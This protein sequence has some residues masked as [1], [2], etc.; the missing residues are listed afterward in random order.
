MKLLIFY[1]QLSKTSGKPVILS[2]ISDYSNAYVPVSQL[3]D[4]S[5]PSTD[6]FDSSAETL[7]FDDLTIKCNEIYDNLMVTADQATLVEKMTRGQAQ[8]TPVV[9]TKSWS[10]H[11]FQDEKCYKYKCG[12]SSTFSHKNY[13]LPRINKIL[14]CG[15]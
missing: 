11:C 1:S 8:I 6:L 2:L 4:Y 5:K 12:Q 3:S 15:L 9:S 7:T 13:L 14:L 10:H